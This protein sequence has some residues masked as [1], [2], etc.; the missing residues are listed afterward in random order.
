MTSSLRVDIE[1]LIAGSV[2]VGGEGLGVLAELLPSTGDAGPSYLYPCVSLP[3]DA[4]REIRGEI[5]RWPTNGVLAADEDGS[6]TYTGTSDYFTFQLYV[7]GVATGTPKS[8]PLVIGGVWPGAVLATSAAGA[9]SASGSLTTATRLAG[10]AVS[11]AS[12]G[13]GLAASAAALVTAASARATAGASLTTAILLAGAAVSKATASAGLAGSP[14]AL[15]ASSS[16][17]AT[18]SASLTTAIRVAG[19]AVSQAT[20]GAG[21]AVPTPAALAALAAAGASA[22]ASLTTPAGL[23]GMAIAKASASATVDRSATIVGERYVVGVPRRW[24]RG[25]VRLPVKAP[26]ERFWIEFNFSADLGK[27]ESI[28]GAELALAVHTGVDPQ[29][30][31]LLVG[32]LVIIGNRVLQMLQGGLDGVV[33]RLACTAATNADQIL[34]RSCSLAVRSPLLH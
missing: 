28:V 15:A 17:M 24:E 25:L 19:A 2:V 32:E 9:A 29:P 34:I 31:L 7:D 14:A 33:Y 21:L 5:T 16:V 22:S 18:T 6:F 3:A 12:A 8:D 1:P 30:E 11:Q 13:A 27:S 20:A 26:G 10:A 23:S 4:G